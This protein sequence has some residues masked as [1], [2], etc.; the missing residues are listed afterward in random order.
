MATN[1]VVGP[2]NIEIVD[3]DNTNDAT[4]DENTQDYDDLATD[5]ATKLTASAEREI[6]GLLGKIE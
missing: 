4:F 3:V 6:E 5:G 1:Q 2:D